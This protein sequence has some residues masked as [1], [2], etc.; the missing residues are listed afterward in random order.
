MALALL[1]ES[2]LIALT[3]PS[4]VDGLWLSANVSS[5]APASTSVE[6][7]EVA[8][9]AGV[10]LG[11]A[12]WLERATTP[13]RASVAKRRTALMT[14]GEPLRSSTRA[15]LLYCTLTACMAPR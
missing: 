4:R 8:V 2:F 15:P 9:V 6:A 7:T 12:L 13:A 5:V 11:E 3:K 14:E 1:L 10:G